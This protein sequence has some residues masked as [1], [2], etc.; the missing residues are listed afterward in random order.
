MDLTEILYSNMDELVI[1]SERLAE[2]IDDYVDLSKV[3]SKSLITDINNFKLKVKNARSEINSIDLLIDE[4]FNYGNLASLKKTKNI[5]DQAYNKTFN[6]NAVQ[7]ESVKQLA[8][9]DISKLSNIANFLMPISLGVAVKGLYDSISSEQLFASVTFASAAYSSI[10][11]YFC[12]DQ[13]KGMD[14]KYKG[15]RNVLVGSV[16]RALDFGKDIITGNL[17]IN[18]M[19]YLVNLVYSIPSS[20]FTHDNK[21]FRK[22]IIGISNYIS[23]VENTKNL[24]QNDLPTFRA[25]KVAEYNLG[26]VNR[27][28]ES[29]KRNNDEFKDQIID[30]ESLLKLA[31]DNNFS[32]ELDKKQIKYIP[33]KQEKISKVKQ[34][35]P[36]QSS[37][38]VSL[39]QEEYEEYFKLNSSFDDNYTSKS[40][41][42][43]NDNINIEVKLDNLN[44][45]FS[46]RLNSQYGSNDVIRN[47]SIT[48]LMDATKRNIEGSTKTQM[49]PNSSIIRNKGSSKKMIKKLIHEHN[50]PCNKTIYKNDLQGYMRAFYVLDSETNDAYV[51]DIVHHKDYDFLSK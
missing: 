5:L 4:N 49:H 27:I 22:S 32:D 31:L 37:Y 35:K 39:S 16:I 29:E 51:L 7:K 48:K 26:Y 8:S 17:S 34:L 24:L 10:T 38:K 20:I 41:S 44:V 33:K 2:S 15:H 18:S 14:K 6:L 19:D 40:V 36:I 28:S 9:S 46:D 42:K 25:I 50:L 43:I 21:K 45:I 23:C 11:S 1:L 30:L 3:N 13:I 47:Y 12:K